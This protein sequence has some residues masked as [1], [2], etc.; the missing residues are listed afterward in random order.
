M[1]A[2][3]ESFLF[4]YN[5]IDNGVIHHFFIFVIFLRMA[6]KMD[7]TFNACIIPE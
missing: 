5:S 2:T 4:I 1:K 7:L 3:Y 6:S